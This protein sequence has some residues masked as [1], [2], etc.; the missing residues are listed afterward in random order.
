MG[1]VGEALKCPVCQDFFTEPVTLQ[2]GHDFCLTCIHAVWE[3]DTS[4]EG[5]FFCPECQIFLAPDVTLEI[6]GDLQK[7]VKDFTANEQP[8]AAETGIKAESSSLIHCDHCIEKPSVAI[9]TCLTCDASLCQAH[10]QLHQQR[11]A[12]KDHMLVDVTK[13]LLLL[14]CREHRD[15]LK[16]FCMEDKIPVCCLCVLVGVHKH[17][18]AS[19]LHEAS[20]DF[21]KSAEDFREKISDKYSR[22]RV[23]LDAD[24][25]LMMQ[26]IDAEET[27]MT[28]WLEA[29]RGITETQIEEI[30]RLRA[31]NK[32]LLQ[33]ANDLQFLQAVNRDL[34][35]HEKLKTVEKLVDDL[36]LALS[37][38]FPRMWSYLSSPALDPKTA[39]PK[40]E[41]SP[42]KKQ[43]CWRRRPV[44]EGLSPQPYDSQYSVLAQESFTNGQHYWEVIVQDKPF[45]MIG[46]TTGLITKKNSPAQ[47]SSSLGVNSTSWCIYHGEGQYLAC[48]DTQE[49]QL[50]VPK[51][52]RKLGILA[53]IQKGELSFYDADA[54]TLLHSFCVQCTQPLYPMF[55]PCIDMNGVN[56]QPLTLFWIKDPWNWEEDEK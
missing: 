6:N 27:Y 13:D 4:T 35:D 28:D 50:S 46:V 36:S 38:Y 25:R 19:P 21:R 40:L 2:C 1:T 53:N 54:M 22:I 18:K 43:V 11:S 32:A 10:T 31:S 5:P 48:H 23:V 45:W 37:Q 16:F 15:E 56:R 47:S 52:V 42:D 44:G 20:G 24:E 41:I 26:I 49:K 17:H 29:Q 51:R 9:R 14:K 30:D 12:L 55:N 39:H 8:A 34:C 3:T 33:E 7:K